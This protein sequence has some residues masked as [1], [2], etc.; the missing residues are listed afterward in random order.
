M[1]CASF[2][3]WCVVLGVATALASSPARGQSSISI[4][5]LVGSSHTDGGSYSNRDQWVLGWHAELAVPVTPSTQLTFGGMHLGVG[6]AGHVVTVT[7]VCFD[8]SRPPD[9]PEVSYFAGTVGVRHTLYRGLGVETDVGVGTLNTN[10]RGRTGTSW[11]A[12]LALA[13]A[14][15]VSLLVNARVLR[16]TMD[17]NTL[18]AYPI[19]GGLRLRF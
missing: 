12:G 17:G 13:M 10:S 14:S 9:V 4:A 19:T 7:P 2:V 15:H 18:Y 3:S 16:W 11:G 5:G 1:K 8:C 6:F